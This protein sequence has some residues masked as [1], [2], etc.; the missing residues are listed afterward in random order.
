MNILQEKD[1]VEYYIKSLA[2]IYSDQTAIVWKGSYRTQ[3]FSYSFVYDNA[4]RVVTLLYSMGIKKG[5]KV[6]IWSYNSPAWVV[7]LFG[8]FLSGIV[9]VPI[10]FISLAEFTISIIKKVEAK[11]ILVSKFKDLDYPINK[12]YSEDLLNSLKN[13]QPAS[14]SDLPE[15][16]TEDLLEIVFTSG[17]TGDPKGVM[18]TNRNLVSNIRAIRHLMTLDPSCRFLSILP[19]SHL[20][21]QVLGLFCP[22]RFG[23][24]IFY[25]STRKSSEII[26]ILRRHKI[27][28]I[29]CVPLFL[30]SLKDTLLRKARQ[31]G[32]YPVLKT[33]LSISAKLPLKVR[34]MLFFM[35]RRGI[36]KDLRFFVCGGA[37]LSESTEDFWR[38]MG[39]RV[40]QGYGLTEASPVVSC[41]VT[42]QYKPYTVGKILP[43]QEILIS[44]DGEILIRGQNVTPGYYRNE[45]ATEMSF[46]NG[47]FKTGDIG[48][49][50]QDGFLVIKGRKK[51][52]ILTSSGLNIF[53]QD[54]EGILNELPSVRES[55]VIAFE[56]DGLTRIHAVI[57]PEAPSKATL[58]EIIK[59]A[60]KRL[61]P[62]Q[63]IH[64]GS[65]WLDK[66]FPKTPSQKINRMEVEKGLK[67][68]KGSGISEKL[69]IEEGERI[70]ADLLELLA[71]FLK[72]S[73]HQIRSNS[74]LIDDLGLDSLSLV[75]L[76]LTLEE[77]FNIDFD[78]SNIGPD[79]TVAELQK[80]IE[81][82][83]I[84]R[85][86]IPKVSWAR[87]PLII[88]VRDTLQ[89]ICRVYL[90]PK[91]N[92]EVKGQE[93]LT[94]LSLPVIIV[95]NH[96]SHLDTFAILFGLPPNIRRQTAVA[97]AADYFFG[98]NRDDEGRARLS[99]K[100]LPFLAPLT[101]NAF[102]FSRKKTIRKSLGLMGELIDDGWSIIIYPE[103][104]RS[105]TGEMSPFKPGIGLIAAE[106]RVPIV[107][108][109][110]KGLFEILPKGR[111]IPSKGRAEVNFGKPLFF[112]GEYNYSL[113]AEK[114]ESAVR[115]L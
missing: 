47:W 97:A 94:T 73:H 40:L 24:T 105:L 39:I 113:I 107:P 57:I 70:R 41:N 88:L 81:S 29:V 36:G 45:E 90:A 61:N 76:G 6:C 89:E 11:A 55:C 21:E 103:G 3:A 15:V 17:T 43:G 59:E 93:F 101:I 14:E 96:V 85:V 52:M 114:I 23:A 58:D 51:E 106:M 20:L 77:R 87:T 9:V 66:E 5:D 69:S 26:R 46:K 35:V 19:L 115:A 65:F 108:V 8:C 44:D 49:V 72:I 99:R 53:P 54:I 84:S 27:T 80:L 28:S 34:R 110:L 64:K 78:E 91:L 79:T 56:Q 100:V 104:T 111:L 25:S 32:K 102:P 86:K 18:I 112:D 4:R 92:L 63:R 12:F 42:N 71:N 50:D 2:E 38:T 31:E 10:D 62:H 16:K 98:I 68:Q 22:L 95:A 37:K 1:T 7:F 60:N 13:I 82:L 75:E 83:A 48:E 67:D 30:D 109:R 33:L 74:K